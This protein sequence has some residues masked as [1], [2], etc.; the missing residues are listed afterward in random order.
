MH[1]NCVSRDD[2]D[3]IAS[4]VVPVVRGVG[5]PLKTFH[6]WANA[7]I[8]YTSCLSFDFSYNCHYKNSKRFWKT[9]L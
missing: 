9:H 7:N 1:V 3:N 4:G 8:F 2:N 6:F 5:G